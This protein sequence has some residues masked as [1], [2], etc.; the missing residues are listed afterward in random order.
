VNADFNSHIFTPI[1][2]QRRF[3]CGFPMGTVLSY[4]MSVMRIINYF[5]DKILDHPLELEFKTF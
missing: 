2:H 4:Y 5:F 1:I 3:Q